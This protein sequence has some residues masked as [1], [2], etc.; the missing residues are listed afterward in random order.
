MTGKDGSLDLS[1]FCQKRQNPFSKRLILYGQI[2]RVRLDLT[3]FRRVGTQISDKLD[4]DGTLSVH[5]R[6][7]TLQ[8]G[9]NWGMAWLVSLGLVGTALPI[10]EGGVG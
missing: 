2:T 4:W 10:A 3:T 7:L 9:C 6:S 1:N 8:R 5:F